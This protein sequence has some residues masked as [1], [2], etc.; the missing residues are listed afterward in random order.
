M[1]SKV[2]PSS[3][4]VVFWNISKEFISHRLPDIRKSS[5]DTI[6]A[7]GTSLNKFI[8]YLESEKHIQREQISFSDFSRDNITDYLDW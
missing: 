3:D 2:S 6:K 5:P 7:Y 1:K 8:D 4:S